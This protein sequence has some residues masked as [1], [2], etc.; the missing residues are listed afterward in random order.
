MNINELKHY[1]KNNKEKLSLSFND[2]SIKEMIENNENV[3]SK[4][5]RAND[6]SIH[7]FYKN[8]SRF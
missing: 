6:Y 4:K 1:I 8:I 2:S 7:K 3:F 5:Y